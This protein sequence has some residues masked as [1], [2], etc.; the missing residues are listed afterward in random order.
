LAPYLALEKEGAMVNYCSNF[1]T[2]AP[3]GSM[4]SSYIKFFLEKSQK[5]ANKSTIGEAREK[6]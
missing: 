2:L 1:I 6:V 5:T 4:A 3:G